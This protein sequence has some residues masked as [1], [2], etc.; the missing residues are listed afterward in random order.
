[1]TGTGLAST[2]RAIV[3]GAAGGG[4]DIADAANTFTVAQALAAG[5]ALTKL[6]DGKLVLSGANSYA[7]GTTIAAGTLQI[8]DGGTTGSILGD[9]LNNGA[10]A[11]NRSDEMTFGGV[12][13]GA[14][15]IEQI[16]AGTTILTAANTYTGGTT[17]TGGTL[18]LGE[19]GSI[20]GDV[21]NDGVLAFNRSDSVTFDGV[22][23][24]AGAVNQIG[25]GKTI[26]T[27]A[28]SYAGGTTITRGALQLGD[29]GTSG[30]IV[31][32]VVNNGLLAF[33]RSDVV[34]FEAYF[35]R[36]GSTDRLGTTILT[37]ANSYTGGTTITAGTLQL[38]DGGTTGH[39]RRCRQQGSSGVQ[40]FRRCDFCGSDF[41][42]G[43]I[44]QNGTGQSTLT[45]DNAFEGITTI[46]PA[47]A[48]G[49][50]WWT[51][52]IVGDC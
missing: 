18:Q 10:L 20:A 22:I 11:F 32:D 51:G 2:P 30:S 21:A 42:H 45:A 50:R 39:H 46:A 43:G 5:G 44:E 25:L 34:T 17:I 8:G 3:W 36:G 9:V 52:G 19:G 47:F 14:G 28:N 38:G 33:N 7:D 24:G 40:P 6:G 16:G 15:S 1:M 35:G 23:S 13:S 48:T 41:G 49:R 26:L 27:G 37:G 4:F 12:I 31:G 29:G